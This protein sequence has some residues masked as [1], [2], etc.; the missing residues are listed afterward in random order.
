VALLSDHISYRSNGNHALAGTFTGR[1]EVAAHLRELF[2]RT[3][4]TFEAAKFEDWLVGEH[5]VAAV[6]TIHAQQH[7]RR[8]SG[9]QV[10]VLGFDTDDRIDRATVFFEDQGA[11]DRFMGS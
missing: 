1:D 11:M 8:Y 3:R 5:H 9:R 10:T 2:E 6:T 7:G 4:G